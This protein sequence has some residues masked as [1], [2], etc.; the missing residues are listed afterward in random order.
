MLTGNL[1]EMAGPAP[2]REYHRPHSDASYSMT[3]FTCFPIVID[4]CRL[5]AWLKLIHNSPLYTSLCHR[6]ATSTP[7]RPAD[8]PSVV[9]PCVLPCPSLLSC[10]HALICS[11]LPDLPFTS[12]VHTSCELQSL[13]SNDRSQDCNLSFSRHLCT[14]RG[15]EL[16]YS[17]ANG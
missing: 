13:S 14:A 12:T 7:I 5:S 1:V 8:I 6:L 10:A 15:H 3:P 4:V 11:P 2:L 16:P 9:R 17:C